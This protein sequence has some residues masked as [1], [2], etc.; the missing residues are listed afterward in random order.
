VLQVKPGLRTDN[1]LTL[2]LSLPNTYKS[3]AE[4]AAF[5]RQAGE[6]LKELPGVA[7]VGLSSCQPLSGNCNTLFFYRADRP[8]TPGQFLVANAV[9]IDPGYLAAAGIPL[10]RGRNLALG[11]GIGFDNK[12]PKVGSILINETMAREFFAGE[13]PIGKLIFYDFEVQRG[14]MQGLPVPK[15]EI[16]GVVG[17]VRSRLERNPQPQMYAPLLDTG[18]GSATVLMHTLVTAQSATGAALGEI[19]KID[20]SLAV[21]NIRTMEDVMGRAAADRRFTLLLFAAFAGLTLLLAAVGLY[22]VLSYGVTQR[23]AEI[24]IRMALG[25]SRADVSRF[26]VWEGMKPA[27]VGVVFGVIAALFATRILK[28]LL[29]GIE[30]LDPLTFSLVPPLLLFVSLVACYLPAVRAARVDPIFALRSE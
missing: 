23:R 28:S 10:L 29:F 24:G 21:Y 6:R 20:A 14:K 18:G 15:Y 13:N 4:D 11:D 25:A 8:F 1:V 19:H 12:N 3:R 17:D 5:Y 22:G 26:V 7:D 2:S 9:S 16:V 30:S 27:A